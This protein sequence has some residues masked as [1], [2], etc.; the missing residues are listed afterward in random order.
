MNNSSGLNFLRFYFSVFFFMVLVSIE[1]IYQTLKTG[2]H[3][4]TSNFVRNTKLR[5]KF[6]FE[7]F[8]NV[9]KLS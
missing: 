5:V 3:F 6:F 8:R 9:V 7:V 2:F 1:K 4:N